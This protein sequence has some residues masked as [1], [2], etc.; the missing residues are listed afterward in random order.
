MMQSVR[1]KQSPTRTYDATK[2]GMMRVQDFAMDQIKTEDKEVEESG[3]LYKGRIKEIRRKGNEKDPK[4]RLV[5]AQVQ[6]R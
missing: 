4:V 6:K 2:A 5:K 1:C 3:I